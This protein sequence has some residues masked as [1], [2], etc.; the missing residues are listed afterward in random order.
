MAGVGD[1]VEEPLLL[2]QLLAENAQL[3]TRVGI[4]EHE[5][6]LHDVLQEQ[7]QR[8]F[9]DVKR[10]LEA[11]MSQGCAEGEVHAGGGSQ[12]VLALVEAMRV[13]GTQNEELLQQM[14]E[15]QA[16]RVVSLNGQVEALGQERDMLRHRVIQLEEEVAAATAAAVV[17]N[18]AQLQEEEQQPQPAPALLAELRSLRAFDALLRHKLNEMQSRSEAATAEAEK[19]VKDGVDASLVVP[20]LLERVEELRVTLHRVEAERELLRLQVQE[21]Q[22]RESVQHALREARLE[23]EL[24]LGRA[25]I[26]SLL[27]RIA[28][29]EA[30]VA[31]ATA[32]AAA[33]TDDI[34]QLHST[35]ETLRV[36][37]TVADET[38]ASKR[39][40]LEQ[41][42]VDNPD[43]VRREL[44]TFWR[45]GRE[46]L[47]QLRE[48]VQGLR[49][50]ERLLR[51]TQEELAQL[52]R[53]RSTVTSKLVTLAEEIGRVR[54]ENQTLRAQ[55]AGLEVERD[56]L[57]GSLA[58][59][60]AHHMEAEDLQRCSET[61]RDAAAKSAAASSNVVADPQAIQQA[62]RQSQEL[63]NEVAQLTKQKE[64]LHRYISL[65]EKRI[66][67]L[68]AREAIHHTEVGEEKPPIAASGGACVLQALTWAELHTNDALSGMEETTT[69]EGSSQR[70]E[71]FASMQ[72][73]I[74]EQEKQL[75][76]FQKQVEEL[77]AAR[78]DAR[79]QVASTQSEL[80]ATLAARESAMVELLRSNTSLTQ[81]VEVLRSEKFQLRTS[82]DAAVAFTQKL[83]TA[84]GGLLELLRAEA[85]FAASLN[86][87]LARDRA[88]IVELTRR[89][90]EAWESREGEV[91]CVVEMLERMCGY[92][93][94]AAEQQERTHTLDDTAH[95]RRLMEAVQQQEARLKDV[96]QGFTQACREFGEGLAQ[97]ITEAQQRSDVVWKKRLGTLLEERQH[98]QAQL[99]AEKDFLVRIERSLVMNAAH[100]TATPAT[101]A[102]A[103]ASVASA[104]TSEGGQQVLDAIDQLLAAMA[105]QDAAVRVSEEETSEPPL[106]VPTTDEAAMNEEVDEEEEEE[107]AMEARLEATESA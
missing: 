27:E 17:P 30:R 28:A 81:S 96:Q 33:R 16:Q 42:M 13:L 5:R 84:L 49:A 73:R 37:Q 70:R 80:R 99:N 24:E 44:V 43:S 98:L 104:D 61:I 12:Q 75:E 79:Q 48:E 15:M 32:E 66:G 107:T 52:E 72:Q 23:D 10:T 68:M 100:Q 106:A 91:Q 34:A 55:Y 46:E 74:V 7:L 38:L 88:E 87:A 103:T 76:A 21:S 77:T 105:S 47:Q 63:K 22:G 102:T 53:T 89:T 67:A 14:N 40:R 41:E 36:Q 64:K 19:L 95:L 85:G 50:K 56:Y 9:G 6:V 92:M 69:T 57:R 20:R 1:G 83:S 59:A 39:R 8:F 45:E 65:R 90:A 2:S 94:Q 101:T 78:D 18:D 58:A 25:T 29:L 51:S 60:L 35:I 54:E 4:P 11:V 71:T 26:Q 62:M 86:D 93:T 3:K 31:A 82:Y 97:R